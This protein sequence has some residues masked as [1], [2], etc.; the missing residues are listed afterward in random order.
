MQKYLAKKQEQRDNQSIVEW[1]DEEFAVIPLVGKVQSLTGI[2]ATLQALILLGVLI[3]KALSGELASEIAVL[4]GT[5]YPFFK[6]IAALQTDTDFEDDKTWLTYWMC[7]GC[8]TVAD[9]HI[10]WILEII[11]FYYTMKLL[12]LVWLQLPLGPLMGAKIVYRVFLK[13]I[14]R[15]IGPAIKAFQERHSDQV[16]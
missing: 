6:S 2:P 4:V 3:W 13:P 10:G 12:L 9:M 7:Y 16:Y 14:F 11:P 8:F 15:C 5:F 1:L